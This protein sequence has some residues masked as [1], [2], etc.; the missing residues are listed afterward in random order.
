M[1]HAK[2]EW[3]SVR[4][5]HVHLHPP[6]DSGVRETTMLLKYLLIWKKRICGKALPLL[7]KVVC[8]TCTDVISEIA[9]HACSEGVTAKWVQDKCAAPIRSDSR[10][11]SDSLRSKY[12]SAL[13]PHLVKRV[14]TTPCTDVISEIANKTCSEGVNAQWV[15]E[16]CCP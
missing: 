15:K 7:V 14:C 5:S 2:A 8:C 4:H 10:F 11:S 13:P 6:G 12:L 1:S 3:T 16:K 9:N